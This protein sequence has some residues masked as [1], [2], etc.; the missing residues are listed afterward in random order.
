MCLGLNLQG[1]KKLLT[2]RISE[3]V[4]AKFWLAVITEVQNYG[5]QGSFLA[6]VDGLSG[7]PEAL[8]T[9][10]PHTLVQLQL[11]LCIFHKVRHLLQSVVWKERRQV[12]LDL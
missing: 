11:Q 2:L 1:E 3:T 5:V 12:A 7:L 6:C 4:E 10:S 8:E 9:V